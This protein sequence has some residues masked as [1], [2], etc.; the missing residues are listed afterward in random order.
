MPL[1]LMHTFYF[2]PND[3]K[4]F[5]VVPHEFPQNFFNVD[6]N[7]SFINPYVPLTRSSNHVVELEVLL[8]VPMISQG[9]YKNSS[10]RLS[11]VF[12]L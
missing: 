7:F 10:S 4:E 3:K 11:R 1:N 2:P 8:R 6:S 5:V 12:S 9:F